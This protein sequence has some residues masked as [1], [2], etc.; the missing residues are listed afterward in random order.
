M[1]NNIINNGILITPPSEFLAGFE[2][3]TNLLNKRGG[4]GVAT[5]LVTWR[6]TVFLI[7]C[8]LSISFSL[9]VIHL[10]LGPILRMYDIQR[11][12]SNLPRISVTV[13]ID[14]VL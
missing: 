13:H 2:R 7:Y 10:I 6:V 8:L 11:T 5:L 9:I 12:K 14:H 1:P 4:G 3:I